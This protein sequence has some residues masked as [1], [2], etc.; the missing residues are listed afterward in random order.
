MTSQRP[1]NRSVWR[2]K[3]LCVGFPIS[4]F[5]EPENEA[6]AVALCRQCEVR[7]ECLHEAKILSKKTPYQTEGIWGG[8]NE[9][10]RNRLRGRK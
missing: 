4:L 2:S 7:L 10:Q 8:T 6:Q 5:F 9:D 1:L 3:A